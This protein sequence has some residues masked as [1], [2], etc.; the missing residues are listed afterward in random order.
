MARE[1]TVGGDVKESSAQT[2][3]ELSTN[4]LL[5]QVD[6]NALGLKTAI[7]LELFMNEKV[8]IYLHADREEGALEVINPAVGGTNQPIVRGRNS[9][10]K[11]K[12]IEALARCHTIKY[13][14]A[15]PDPSRP[16]NISLIARKIPDYPFDVVTDTRRG[17]EWVKQ[18]QASI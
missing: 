1:T 5:E 7:E 10:V 13:T 14:Q 11:R 18:L 9:V 8:E 4:Q 2:I 6:G 3:P 16:E 12:Y 15:A 17:R